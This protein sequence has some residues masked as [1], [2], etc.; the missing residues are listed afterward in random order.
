MNCPQKRIHK[1]LINFKGKMEKLIN[2]GVQL[3]ILFIFK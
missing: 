2:S 3:E 1:K